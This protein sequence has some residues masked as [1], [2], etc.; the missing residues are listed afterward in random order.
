M[1]TFLQS[2]ALVL[3][4]RRLQAAGQD[5]AS[6][7]SHEGGDDDSAD[8]AGASLAQLAAGAARAGVAAAAG[9]GWAAVAGLLLPSVAADGRWGLAEGG[10]GGS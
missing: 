1:D 2:I 6:P 8:P 9:R 5:A 3:R 4:H 7:G 10:G